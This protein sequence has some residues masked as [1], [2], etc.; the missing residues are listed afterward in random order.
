MSDDNFRGISACFVLHVLNSSL[1]MSTQE[2]C[3]GGVGSLPLNIDFSQYLTIT[4]TC[5]LNNLLLAV[6][7]EFMV[8]VSLSVSP[9]LPV[10]RD[11]VMIMP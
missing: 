7:G 5:V 2:H 9:F 11:A 8:N 1:V 4:A 6:C 3:Q 10:K